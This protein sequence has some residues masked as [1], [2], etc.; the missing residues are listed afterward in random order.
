MDFRILGPLEVWDDGRQVAVGGPQQCALLAVLVLGA[1]K[2]VS[3][4]RLVSE[5]WS[6]PPPPAA[7]RLLQGC[8]VRLRRVL[9][10]DRLVTRSPGYVLEVRPGELD[11]DRFD[12]L[13]AAADPLLGKRSP[14]ALDEAGRLLTDALALW[15]GPALDGIDTQTCQ[16]QARRLDERRQAA[17]EAR[18][19][20]DL[21][22]GCHAELVGELRAHVHAHPLRERLWAQLI[23][24]LYGAERQADALAAYREVRHNLVEQ[25]GAE[26]NA[27][28]KGIE[29]T[30]LAGGDA[31]EEYRSARG[32]GHDVVPAQL[33][34]AIAAFTGREAHLKELDERLGLP[35]VSVTVIEGTAGVGKTALAVHWAH[36]VRDR[37]S[38]G[39]L[40]VNL[41][42]YAP[43]PPMR[44]I[45]ALVGFLYALGVPADKIP[46]ELDQVAALYR[47]L[48]ADRRVLIVLDNARSP[49]QVRP[50]LPGGA[51][52]LVLITSRDKLNALVALDG[53]GR[54]TL[55]AFA[56]DEASLLLAR[57][58]GGDRVAAE[59]EATAG[60][61]KACA[62]LP[63]A[64]RI[65]AANLTS[66]PW[67]GIA[68]FG[69]VD[70]KVGEDEAVRAAFDL[71]YTALAPAVQRMFRLL[72]MLPG[73]DVTR[74]AAA[75]L[76]GTTAQE[77]ERLL[78]RL[79]G[80]HLLS[81]YMPGRYTFHDLLRAYAAGLAH[82]DEAAQRLYDWYVDATRAAVTLL[83]PH[84][85]FLPHPACAAGFA[86]H[87]K[88]LAWLDEERPNLLAA[89][90]HGPP[91]AAWLLADALRGY[92][93]ARMHTVDWLTI[94]EAGLAA[95]RA[96]GDLKAQA[97]ARLSLGDVHQRL[98]Q[99]P[100]AVDHY[101][102]GL[103]LAR[104]AE[105]LDG[106][107]ALLRNLGNVYWPLGRLG[108]AAEHYRQALALYE[109]TG[110]LAGQAL[111]VGSLGLASRH[112][113]RLAEAAAHLGRA[114]VLFRQIGS[115]SAEAACCGNLGEV[116]HDLG[117]F[118]HAIDHLTRSLELYRETGD[119]G[120]EADTL[121]VL[122]AVH[123]DT[124][125]DQRAFELARAAL[126]LAA[127]IGDRRVEANALN[128]LAGVHERL[129]RHDQAVDGHLRALDLANESGNVYPK[130]VALL[131][132]GRAREALAVSR[133]FG[134]RTLEGHALTALGAEHAKLALDIHRETGHRLGQARTLL[135][136][137]HMLGGAE[138]VAHWREGVALYEEMGASSCVPAAFQ[139]PPG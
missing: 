30:I 61:A 7:R 14:E 118:D 122:A 29:R 39:Q 47:S 34:A 130:V 18:V 16:T 55:D 31:L 119:R 38:D 62:F 106:Q 99:Y 8:V 94:A 73:P 37:F 35:V 15:R 102:L 105:W 97:A 33:P 114:L 52:C 11:A 9:P 28:L 65:A 68:A 134:Y 101:T 58:L 117:R 42:G 133:E 64:L 111:S 3:A 12:D 6:E 131:G 135:M 107:A 129:G 103:D 54:I 87:A 77:A 81:Q 51:G 44:P 138:G 36:L 5:L 123:R 126:D 46:V 48:L 125:A 25:L 69:L 17:L 113:G 27:V 83:Y 32:Y 72:G 98:S 71:S 43:N 110:Q 19:D 59:P 95:A 139:Q 132:L 23:L 21:Y 75:A 49:E 82:D 1:N 84:M 78:D 85:L 2:V 91:R 20:V 79:A 109:Q 121:R 86:D 108:D 13:V 26:P 80:A 120:G 127:D 24:A 92:L 115:R 128:T 41:R 22:R 40:Y 66:Q 100:R 104:Q 124:G 50:L 56:P 45:D 96:D 74:D 60:L 93:M 4:D 76:A 89:V 63:L 10:A 57:I 112:L 67:R 88:A 70:L 116:H 137:G 136:L 90:T 53:A